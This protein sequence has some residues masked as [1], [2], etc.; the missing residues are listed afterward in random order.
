[1]PEQGVS[2]SRGF[3]SAT[4]L[5]NALSRQPAEQRAVLVLRFLCEV[6]VNEVGE[7]LGCSPGTVKSQTS[8]EH[9]SCCR[10]R[11]SPVSRASTVSGSTTCEAS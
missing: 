8:T 11:R 5:R 2:E 10:R 7:M 1:M 3:E 4:A 6:P 9:S